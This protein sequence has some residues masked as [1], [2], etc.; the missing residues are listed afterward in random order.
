MDRRDFVKTM[1]VSTGALMAGSQFYCQ[2]GKDLPNIFPK[3]SRPEKLV[4]MDL[5]K[6]TD[7]HTKTSLACFQGLINRK[8]TRFYLNNF[9]ADMFWLKQYA[10]EYK[11]D[12][13]LVS[14]IQNLVEMF[15]NDIEGFIVYDPDMPHSLNI[16]TSM[17][18][19]QNAVPVSKH[20][21]ADVSE[22]GI[23]KIDDLTGKWK[24][25]YEA[26][27]WALTNLQPQCNQK[28]MAHLCVHDPY[29]PTSSWTNRDYVIAHKILSVDISSSERDKRD[30]NLLKKYYQVYPEETV[31]FGWHCVRDKEHEAI[32]LS[33]EYGHYGMCSLHTSNLTVHS[34]IRP[35]KRTIYKQRSI[36][37]N[38][39]KVEN[40]VYIA[41]MDTD[42][43]ASWF[44]QDLISNDW[45]SPAHG[46]IKYNWGFLPMAYD[47]LPA[48]VDY[49][50]KNLKPT[51]YFVAGPAGATYTYP[52]LHPNPRKFLRLSQQYMDKCGLTTVH[53]TNWNDRD[54]WQEVDLPHFPA[55]LRETM[56][57]CVGYTRGMGESAFEKHYIEGGQPF[58]FCGEGLHRGD[59]IYKVMNEF[60]EASP[61]RPL[62]IYCL[63]NHTMPIA[64]TK[65]A[66][67]R[68]SKD[69]VELVHLDELLLLI[70]KAYEEG[71]ITEELYPEKAGIKKLLARDAK[72]SWPGFNKS[73]ADAREVYIQGETFYLQEVR[74]SAIGLEAI[75]PADFLAFATIWQAMKM[76]KIAL[77]SK[78]IYVN[79]KPTANKQF[80]EEF[81]NVPDVDLVL[82]LQKQWD[83]WHKTTFEFDSAIKYAERL[84]NIVSVLNN[85]HFKKI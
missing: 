49:Y 37:K 40:K 23:K 47:F 1:L 78:G 33:S 21:A 60:I 67:D 84:A 64:D 68:F 3:G 12:Y 72:K 9:K 28:L 19:L 13:Q 58:I 62:F 85:K 70:E 66:M 71:K 59:D 14:N 27:E 38:D 79:H 69:Q 11:I 48:M 18:A 75:N 32:A 54:W 53:M 50:F 25:L 17:G 57:N 22:L 39:L 30:Y 35:K 31:I 34:S 45:N 80:V 8:A 24:D 82:E 6:K 74:K 83:N 43:D 56:P 7:W 36:H 63:V 81:K 55:L 51:D 41:F 61:N 65:A 44:V 15:G 20:L 46:Q 77:E 16:A 5:P 26:Y 76:V 10:E 52:H 73:I 42:G 2:P 4:Y 29:W